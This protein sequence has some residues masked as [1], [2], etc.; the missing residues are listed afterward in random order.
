M[1]NMW[2]LASSSWAM[3]F[4]GAYNSLNEG[5]RNIPTVL[6]DLVQY[7]VAVSDLYKECSAPWDGLYSYCGP[8]TAICLGAQVPIFCDD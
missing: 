2:S 3:G 8:L 4:K 7:Q 5:M 6:C 1:C